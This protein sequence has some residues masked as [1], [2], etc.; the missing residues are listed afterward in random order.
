MRL[1]PY[2]GAMKIMAIKTVRE[3]G[4]EVVLVLAL[5]DR[6]QGAEQLFRSEGIVNYQPVFTIRDFGVEV[7]A[8][9]HATTV[10]Q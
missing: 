2:S 5:V 6:L 4:C 8:S 3:W 9:E 10:P 1:L 7:H